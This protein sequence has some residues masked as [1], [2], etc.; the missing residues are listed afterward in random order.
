[1]AHLPEVNLFLELVG[2]AYKRVSVPQVFYK[3][4]YFRDRKVTE[5]IHSKTPFSI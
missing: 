5:V 1:M 2:S 3:R 4:G